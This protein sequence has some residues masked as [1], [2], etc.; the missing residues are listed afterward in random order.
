MAFFVAGRVRNCREFRKCFRTRRGLSQFRPETA[1]E[2]RRQVGDIHTLGNQE[3][4]TQD[5]TRL[6]VVRQLAI[7]PAVLA[8]LVP[9]ETAVRNRLWADELKGAQKR[10]S[11]GH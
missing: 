11:L 10:I 4:T 5:G 6:I 7:D 9:T 3:F 8:V 2:F 1:N